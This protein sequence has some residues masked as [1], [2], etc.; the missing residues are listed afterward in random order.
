MHPLGAGGLS[1]INLT[2]GELCVTV[3]KYEKRKNCGWREM[4]GTS[5]AFQV[6]PLMNIFPQSTYFN[7]EYLFL[8]LLF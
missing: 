1:N 7:V 8:T 3:L 2:L 6:T 5:H 4:G